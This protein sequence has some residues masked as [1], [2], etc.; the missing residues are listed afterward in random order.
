MKPQAI[1]LTPAETASS[2]I[3]KRETRSMSEKVTIEVDP[4]ARTIKVN[5]QVTNDLYGLQRYFQHVAIA[6]NTIQ[7]DDAFPRLELSAPPTMTS[8]P[9]A[10]KS[11]PAPLPPPAFDVHR[12]AD[13]S[14]AQLDPKLH[15]DIL[16]FFEADDPCN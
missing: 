8:Q 14:E 2:S 6:R 11:T 13:R 4:T 16:R 9:L 7:G 5:G 1:D 12:V 3:T 10:P 15:R